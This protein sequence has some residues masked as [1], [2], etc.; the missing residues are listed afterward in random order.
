MSS[1][2]IEP[3]APRC[4]KGPKVKERLLCKIHKEKAETFKLPRW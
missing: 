3:G 4:L 1:A 2:H